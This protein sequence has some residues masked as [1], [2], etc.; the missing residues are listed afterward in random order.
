MPLRLDVRLC[1]QASIEL[2]RVASED[3]NLD[4]PLLKDRII[5]FIDR[6]KPLSGDSDELWREFIRTVVGN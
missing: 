2:A 6:V 3:R 5:G 1:A 4:P